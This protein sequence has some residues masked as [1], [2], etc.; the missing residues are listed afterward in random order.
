[1]E[2]KPEQNGR[3]QTHTHTQMPVGKKSFSEKRANEGKKRDGDE[4]VAEI[5]VIVTQSKWL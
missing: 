1:M 4:K 2:P 5:G 3:A